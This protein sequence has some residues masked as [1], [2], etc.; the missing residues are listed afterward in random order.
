MRDVL[1][2]TV[3]IGSRYASVNGLGANGHRAGKKSPEYH[4]LFDDVKRAAEAEIARTGW[5]TAECDCFAMIVR[6]VENRKR[7]D[8]MNLA[9]VEW[10]SLTAAG[11]WTDDSLANPC[12]PMIRYSTPHRITIVV[13]KLYESVL[14]PVECPPGVQASRPRRSAQAGNDV[15]KPDAG[16]ATAASGSSRRRAPASGTSALHLSWKPGDPIP[17]GHALLNG[18]LVTRKVALEKAGI[19]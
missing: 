12:L 3:P 8:A 10:D 16:P 13:V 15:P 17:D 14:T 18:K 5:T 6:Y 2:I 7:H 19:A 11:V 4:T 9:K 1:S